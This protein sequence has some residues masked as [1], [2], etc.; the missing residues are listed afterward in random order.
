MSTKVPLC[1]GELFTSFS[2]IAKG[3]DVP[4]RAILALNV[5]TEVAYGMSQDGCTA[6]SWKTN[7]TSTGGG[8]SFLAQNWDWQEEQRQNL[9]HLQIHRRSQ[10]IPAISMITEAGIIGKIG[11]NEKGVGVCLNAIGAVGVDFARVP[12]HLALRS[13]LEGE[14]AA[15]AAD[16]LKRLGVASA[17][18]ILVA[19]EKG[20]V[21]LEC[22]SQDV[23]PLLPDSHGIVTHTNHFVKRHVDGVQDKITLKDSPLRL[24]RLEALVQEHFTVEKHGDGKMEADAIQAFLKDEMNSPTSI[25]RSPSKESTMATLFSIVMDLT[26][27]KAGVTIGRPSQ[28]QA[29]ILRLDPLSN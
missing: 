23:V 19:D 18:H 26:K 10:E 22:S 17:C 29:E 25:C 14:S 24:Q 12:T 6:L 1:I 4:Y 3:A 21:G 7:S 20:G 16:R 13:C 11:L 2:G 28:A 15:A 8:T 27:V 9:I 5:R